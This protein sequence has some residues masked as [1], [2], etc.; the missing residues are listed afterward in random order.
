MDTLNTKTKV[1]R[2]NSKRNSILIGQSPEVSAWRVFYRSMGL[3][4]LLFIATFTI[5]IQ[6]ERRITREIEQKDTNR[7]NQSSSFKIYVYCCQGLQT[8]REGDS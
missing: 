4:K 1:K 8:G 6:I 2:F 3:N 7:L 5:E